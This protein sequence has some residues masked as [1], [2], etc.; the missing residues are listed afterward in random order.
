MAG[1]EPR[2]G[3]VATYMREGDQAESRRVKDF[4]L[5]YMTAAWEDVCQISNL[6]SKLRKVRLS[7]TI[8]RLQRDRAVRQRRPDIDDRAAI[9]IAHTPQRRHR[10]MHLPEI[11][12]PG[13]AQHFLGR[14]RG[15]RRESRRH[16]IVHPN[17]DRSQH[18]LNAS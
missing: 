13:G 2:L 16:G 18:L 5:Y 8:G 17:V 14:Q 9:A 11:S 7:C 15:D 6:N 4:L 12:D 10:A 3:M 1:G